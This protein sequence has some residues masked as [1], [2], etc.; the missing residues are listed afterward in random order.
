MRIG[1][2]LIPV[3]SVVWRRDACEPTDGCV[4]DLSSELLSLDVGIFRVALVVFV[5]LAVRALATCAVVVGSFISARTADFSLWLF[6]KGGVTGRRVISVS[7]IEEGREG[8]IKRKIYCMGLGSAFFNC[9][10]YPS[11]FDVK[12]HNDNTLKQMTLPVPELLQHC[13]FTFTI[14]DIMKNLSAK[15]ASISTQKCHICQVVVL[16]W[17]AL[18][19]GSSFTI[20]RPSGQMQRSRTPQAATPSFPQIPMATV[21]ACTKLIERKFHLRCAFRSLYPS[22]QSPFWTN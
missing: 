9:W 5:G 6:S 1:L 4:S 15:M 8:K 12:R 21:S 17:E 19:W 16:E 18:C 14:L 3:E 13:H 7:M 22:I 2:S 11:K 20:F 10:K